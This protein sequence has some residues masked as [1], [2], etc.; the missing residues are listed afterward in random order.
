MD[1][2][3]RSGAIET[4]AGAGDGHNTPV[5]LG[6]LGAE[7]D[8]AEPW[9]AVDGRRRADLSHGLS[10]SGSVSRS[11]RPLSGRG[12]ER[13]GGWKRPDGEHVRKLP[14]TFAHALGSGAEGV[15]EGTVAD[16]ELDLRRIV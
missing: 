13:Q 6:L 15:D 4:A 7:T 1:R 9:I 5:V 12:V 3:P 11:G 16:A 10:A 8:V 14:G 2:Y